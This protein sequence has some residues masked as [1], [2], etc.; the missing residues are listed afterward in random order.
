[1]NLRLF[2]LADHAIEP[3]EMH[4]GPGASLVLQGVK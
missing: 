3:L 4:L 2:L 1:M